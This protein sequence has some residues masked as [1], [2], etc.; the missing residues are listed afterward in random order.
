M[1]LPSLKEFTESFDTTKKESGDVV[2]LVNNFI[3]VYMH[4][5]ESEKQV[6]NTQK[7]EDLKK[8]QHLVKNLAIVVATDLDFQYNCGHCDKL[9]SSDTL[10]YYP[11]NKTKYYCKNRDLRI[12]E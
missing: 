7:I 10:I 8:V 9:H 12:I 2:H 11:H 1:K 5:Y 4:E 6:V 3:P